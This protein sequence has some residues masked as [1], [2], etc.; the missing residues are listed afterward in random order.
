MKK[1]APF[2]W[3]ES[4][5]TTFKKIKK[6]LSHP[7]VLEASIP[8]KHLILYITAKEKSLEALCVQEMR[9]EK[10]FPCAT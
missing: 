1:G 10:K 9:K 2:E 3:D 4:C 8:G 6:Y 5:G 7:S